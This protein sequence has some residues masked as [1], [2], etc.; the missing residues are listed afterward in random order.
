MSNAD[1]IR[2][3]ARAAPAGFLRQACLEEGIEASQISVLGDDATD[4]LVAR[5]QSYGERTA[6]RY[7]R[8]DRGDGGDYVRGHQY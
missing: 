1:R 4:R 6:V 2:A 7:S 5:L 8:H 3:A